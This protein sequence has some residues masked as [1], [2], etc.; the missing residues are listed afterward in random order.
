V[1]VVL[2]SR[3][4][5]ESKRLF[6]NYDAFSFALA[7]FVKHLGQNHQIIFPTEKPKDYRSAPEILA[8]LGYFQHAP[9]SIHPLIPRES[10]DDAVTAHLQP[11]NRKHLPETHKNQQPVKKLTNL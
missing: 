3:C 1:P 9:P 10:H 2:V 4:R 6:S 7:L 11:D 8:G 5:A